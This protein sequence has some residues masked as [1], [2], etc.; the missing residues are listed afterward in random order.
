V[1][2]TI[3]TMGITITGI[4]TMDIT[5]TMAGITTATASMSAAAAAWCDGWCRR[6]GVRAGAG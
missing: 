1:A 5:I 4:T 2:I 6:P 3:I